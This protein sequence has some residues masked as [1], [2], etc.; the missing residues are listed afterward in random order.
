MYQITYQKRNGDIFYRE[1]WT[2]PDHK[3]GEET[4]MGWKILDIK[5]YFK[6]KYY[7]APEY[8]KI[9]SKW[10]KRNRKILYIKN[11]FKKYMPNL[12]TIVVCVTLSHII[13]K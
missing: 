5:E 13:I 9:Y 2:L 4:S 12:A 1:R 8:Y 7:S 11:I 6:G 10:K 3:I